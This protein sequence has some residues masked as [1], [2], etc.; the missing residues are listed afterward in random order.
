MTKSSPL[1]AHLAIALSAITLLL[2]VLLHFLSPEFDPAWRMISEYANGR[3]EGVI[4][5]L[6]IVWGLSNWLLSYALRPLMTSGKGKMG[7][8]FLVV[9]GLGAL[10]ASVFD[11][12]HPLHGLVAFFGIG[13]LSVAAIL[14]GG[15]LR[16]KGGPASKWLFWVSQLPWIS[17]LIF[18]AMMTAYAQSGGD[19]N[20]SSAEVAE[21]PQGAIAVAGYAQRLLV[22]VY[23]GWTALVASQVRRFA[24]NERTR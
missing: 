23:C 13:G 16:R 15:E 5:T 19:L 4:A 17:A 3:Y 1:V 21:L 14:I 9:S 8:G 22:L 7:L 10:L 18:V 6:F 20:A 11:I 12:N 24:V 2:L